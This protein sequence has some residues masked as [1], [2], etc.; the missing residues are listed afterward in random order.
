MFTRGGERRGGG[1]RDG[2]E[3]G[4]GW[5]ENGEGGKG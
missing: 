3:M 4:K 2:V 1:I 5:E